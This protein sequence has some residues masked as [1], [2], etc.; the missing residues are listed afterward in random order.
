MPKKYVWIVMRKFRI[1]E[2][3][4]P[5]PTVVLSYCSQSSGD[6]HLA[7][8]TWHLKKKAL[9]SLLFLFHISFKK[10]NCC[11][12]ISFRVVANFS[13]YCKEAVVAD[14]FKCFKVVWPI[15]ATLT[16]RNLNKWIVCYDNILLNSVNDFGIS[17]ENLFSVFCVCVDYVFFKIIFLW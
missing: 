12:D 1:T 9:S 8:G 16:E 2:R 14:F 5:L 15:N 7:S 3:S 10:F 13:F 4:M 11:S 17:E 6:W